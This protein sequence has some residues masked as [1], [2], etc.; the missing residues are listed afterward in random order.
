MFDANLWRHLIGHLDDVYPGSAHASVLGAAPE[1]IE[2]WEH[3][4]ANGFVVA[5]KDSDFYRMSM[6]WG[7]PPEVVWLRLGNSTTHAV[8]NVLRAQLAD[9]RAFCNDKTSALLILGRDL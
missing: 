4:K 9:V 8:E 5:T 1:D 6:A 2:I 7:P 3:A